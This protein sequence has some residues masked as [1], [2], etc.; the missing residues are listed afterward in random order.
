M[1]LNI[2][3]FRTVCKIIQDVLWVSHPYS[4]LFSL[5]SFILCRQKNGMETKEYF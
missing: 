2:A 3:A 4:V 1:L 5:L